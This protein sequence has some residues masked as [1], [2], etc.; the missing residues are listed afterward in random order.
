MP[1]SNRPGQE[2]TYPALDAWRE[3][4]LR[5]DDS[6]F[7]PGR[8]IWTLA[9][10]EENHRR[11]VQALDESKATY[12]EKLA[13]QLAGA[14]DE[15][16]QCA[17]EIEWALVVMSQSTNPNGVDMKQATKRKAV[18]DVL[19]H[20]ASPVDIPET[21]E[22]SLAAGLCNTGMAGRGLRWV[23][24]LFVIE[25]GVNW[26]KLPEADR[27]RYLSDP[28]AFKGWL[29]SLPSHSGLSLRE[30]IL[31]YMHPDTFEIII[32]GGHKQKIASAFR[33]RAGGA[34]DVD[35]ALLAIRKSFEDEW[36]GPFDFYLDPVKGWWHDGQVPPGG[37]T[38][39]PHSTA[40]TR[41]DGST[42]R[43][44]PVTAELARRLFLP[45]DWLQEDL[46]DLL[47]DKR[48]IVLY[49]PP[50]TGKTYVA[51]AVAAH[52]AS[53]GGEAHL[54]QFHPSYA[55]ED[56]F[57]GYRPIGASES[58]SVVFDLQPGPL[59]LI[60]DAAA[61]D[62]AR[63]Y[64]LVI[65]ELNRANLAKVFGELYFLLEYRDRDIGLQYRP[66][67]TY[68]LPENLYLIGTM[69]TADRSIALVDA[70]MRRRFY[71]VD[72]F[73]ARWPVDGVLP[74]WLEEYGLPEEP[75]HL[76]A[77]LN[78]RLDNEDFAIGPSYVMTP[79]VGRPGGLERIWK[80][81]I[82]P[83]LEEHFYGTQRDVADEFGLAS[84]RADLRADIDG[85]AAAD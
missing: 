7:A 78:E 73:P 17:A 19:D 44:P 43:L 62:P 31:H 21:V 84:L 8:P 9:N 13:R 69:N 15:V 4:C 46:V 67:Q 26:K 53:S 24:R 49:G 3:R 40:Q 50:G 42:P 34:T 65:D 45:M 12:V 38:A 11:F 77:I 72:M 37:S 1:R 18:Q 66:G 55:Y 39:A 36:D 48:Q 83:L 85:T 70:A 74:L 6:L 22:R 47:E 10:L 20:M 30:A 64:V 52:L 33:D 71:F 58:G 41:N 54:I 61:K 56:F 14:S 23:G 5:E 76:L 80:R 57:E 16:I 81:A 2:A 75:G 32:N 51:M 28:W 79:Q 63:P 59:K 29:F 25:F 27:D 35:R 82:L 60:A 68:R